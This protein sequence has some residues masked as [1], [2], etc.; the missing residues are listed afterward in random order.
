[1]KAKLNAASANTTCVQKDLPVLPFSSCKLNSSS[2]INFHRY[3]S[4]L[5]V[6]TAKNTCAE[7][8]CGTNAS[9]QDL[10][11]M[12]V[13]V[14]E[15]PL[16]SGYTCQKK[17]TDTSSGT[18]SW[19]CEVVEKAQAAGLISAT[20]KQ[21]RPLDTI[22]RAEAYSILLKS[23]CIH[24]STTSQNWQT[25]VAKTAKKYGFTTRS[26]TNFE[27]NKPILRQELFVLT[28]RV[29]EW[30]AKNPNSCS[31]LPDTLICK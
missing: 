16:E 3:L 10:T 6:V 19:V 20:N 30:K 28:A 26:T 22:T 21:F 17:H 12:A 9:R 5:G 24:P 31:V 23:I 27:P 8:G 13:R 15:I 14:R 25:E 2:F 4:C 11:A 18:A 29:A 1:M 7:A